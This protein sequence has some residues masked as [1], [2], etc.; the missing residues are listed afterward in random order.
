MLESEQDVVL[1]KHELY[2][3][4]VM[5]ERYPH[6]LAVEGEMT[7]QERVNFLVSEW[8]DADNE[9][10]KIKAKEKE[11]REIVVTLAEAK[12]KGT[13]V[14]RTG[15][16][17]VKISRTLEGKYP[18]VGDVSPAQEIFARF[19]KFREAF[20][21]SFEERYS[22]MEALLEDVRSR[23]EEGLVNAEEVEAHEYILKHRRV[24]TSSPQVKASK[25]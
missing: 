20:R 10:A 25:L 18:K 2:T 3:L 1:E 7:V 15:M 23:R 8:I 6:V 24:T 14:L 9:L 17:E 13:S 16:H 19:P 11:L 12:E 21:V 4:K 5:Q 22:A